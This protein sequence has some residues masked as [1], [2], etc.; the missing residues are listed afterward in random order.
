MGRNKSITLNK[1]NKIKAMNTLDKNMIS[2][3][4]MSLDKMKEELL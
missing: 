2:I 1:M 3:H 4:S